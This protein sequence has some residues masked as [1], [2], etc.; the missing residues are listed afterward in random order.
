MRCTAE[1]SRQGVDIVVPIEERWYRVD[2]AESG[3][4]WR[5]TGP[6]EAGNRQFVLSDPDGYLWRPFRDLGTRPLAI[7][8]RGGSGHGSA[9]GA[10]PIR[11]RKIRSSG[12]TQ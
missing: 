2:V 10:D 1:R 12:R 5:M 11:V 8:P 3:G 6:T 7:E 9:L 4:R